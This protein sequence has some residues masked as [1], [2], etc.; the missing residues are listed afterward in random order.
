[1]R[2]SVFLICITCAL[3][4]CEKKTDFAIIDAAVK[5]N[6]EN[7]RKKRLTDCYDI[8]FAVANRIVDSILKEEAYERLLS[9]DTLFPPERPTR[10]PKINTASPLDTMKVKPLF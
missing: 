8:R 4:A 9:Q 2:L 6:I 10:P 5:Q 3:V 1:M 7:Y